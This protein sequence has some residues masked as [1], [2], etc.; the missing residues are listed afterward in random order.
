M[1]ENENEPL[2]P[3]PEEIADWVTARRDEG[4]GF[5]AVPGR[6][7]KTKERAKPIP[8]HQ[9]SVA[10]IVGGPVMVRKG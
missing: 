4:Y 5:L 8:T 2:K 3:T 7:D 10:A 6:A 9:L 1:L